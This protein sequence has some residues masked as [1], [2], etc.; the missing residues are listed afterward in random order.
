MLVADCSCLSRFRRRG[1]RPLLAW[2]CGRPVAA[3]LRLLSGATTAPPPPHPGWEWR[4]CSVVFVDCAGL[5]GG[6]ARVAAFLG[7]PDELE[8]GEGCKMTPA[9]ARI[10]SHQKWT[11]SGLNRGPYECKSYALPLRYT[12][13]PAKHAASQEFLAESGPIRSQS[14]TRFLFSALC[15]I[16]RP[17]RC[18]TALVLCCPDSMLRCKA[19]GLVPVGRA[20]GF[21]GWGDLCFISLDGS[22][23]VR[24]APRC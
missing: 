1:D 22:R 4:P 11:S 5:R 3:C 20:S 6:G 8:D 15:S 2:W 16:C 19:L 14:S 13:T 24:K 21:L 7:P 9:I 18:R 23:R 12:P 10:S 17:P